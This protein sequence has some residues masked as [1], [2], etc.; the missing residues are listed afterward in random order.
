[1]EAPSITDP[2]LGQRFSAE[3]GATCLKLSSK[4]TDCGPSKIGSPLNQLKK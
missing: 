1:M 2:V 4:M 3:D